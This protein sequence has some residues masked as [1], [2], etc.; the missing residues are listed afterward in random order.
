MLKQNKG[1]QQNRVEILQVLQ[2]IL[3]ENSF[4]YEGKFY[5]H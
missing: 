5:K 1:E 4:Q 2:I 3:N